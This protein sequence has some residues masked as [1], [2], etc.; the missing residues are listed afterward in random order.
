MNLF[1]TANN[2]DMGKTY[3][4]LKLIE[5]LGKEFKVGVFKPIETGVKEYPLDGKKLFK[6]T[7]AFL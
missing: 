1:I 4:T 2:T 6:N 5:K 3:T 7:T